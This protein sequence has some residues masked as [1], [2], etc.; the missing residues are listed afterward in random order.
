MRPRPAEPPAS[1]PLAVAVLAVLAG[2]T[3]ALALADPW[4]GQPHGWLQVLGLAALVALLVDAPWRRALWLGWL[5]ALAWLAGSFWWLFISMHTYGGLN[6]LLAA[7]A[8][9]LLAGGLALPYCGACALFAWLGQPRAARAAA[10]AL[11][12]A[13]FWTL[14]ELARGR[15]LTGFPWG[16]GGYAHVDGWLA[17]WAR[18]IGVYGVGFLAAW[19]AALLALL[20]RAGGSRWRQ[21]PALLVA[22]LVLACGGLGPLLTSANDPQ[23]TSV[24]AGLHVALLQGNIPQDEK[25][26]PGTGIADSLAWYGEQLQANTAALVVAPE[27][28]LPVLPGQLPE[29]YWQAL[30]ARYAGS[31][32]AALLGM[33]LGDPLAGYTNSAVGLAP[34]QAQPYRYDKHHLVPFGE[35]IPPFFR[36]FVQMMNIPLGD[37]TRGGIDQPSFAW[38][39]ERLAPNICYEDLFGEELGARFADPA[40]APTVFVNL[41]NIAW[42]GDTVAIDQHLAISRMRALEFERP[43]LRATNTGA[44][45]IIDHRGRVVQQLPRLTRGVLTGTVHGRSAFTPYA[46]WVSQAGLWPL[47]ALCLLITG[48]ALWRR[49]RHA[50]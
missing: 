32:Q 7:L 30:Q 11:L 26:I 13:A 37:F 38:Q 14:A 25:F 17:G 19:L 41:S 49:K 16:A 6:P 4:S 8:V 42:F 3:Q 28:A 10:T 18:W 20:A 34:G 48:H 44:T 22:G 46:R 24:G 1:P 47:W 40:T 45:A 33:P 29:G 21:A 50:G 9:L 2:A 36:W 15:W 5:F 39:G 31:G 35:F 43:V 12:F 27:T 23:D